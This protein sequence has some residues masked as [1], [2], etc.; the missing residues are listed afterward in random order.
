MRKA[1]ETQRRLGCQS[2]EQL[3]LNLDC[4]DEIV[5]ILQALKHVFRQTI[6]RDR[7]CQLVAGDVNQATRND[8]GREGFDYW[9]ILVMAIVRLGCNLDYDKLQD[10][11]ENHRALRCLLTVGDWDES[12]S[13]ASRRI[14][15]TLAML[16]PATITSINQLIVEHAQDV[17]GDARRSIR[18][19]SFVVETNIHHPTE[20]SLIFDGAKKIIPLCVRLAKLTGAS[21]W[22]QAKHLRKVIKQQAREIARISASKSPRVTATLPAAYEKLLSRMV[23][24][25]QRA[26]TLKTQ[27][28][29]HSSSLAVIGL[30]AHCL[31]YT[32]PSP[33]DATLSRMPSSA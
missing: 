27:A 24:L 7:L 12:T 16:K 15:D 33:R 18:A 29:E 3:R 6:L 11:C 13:F 31:L 19:D 5:P 20:S 22:R 14:R 9:Q 26:E 23:D 21:G 2:I 30:I 1:Y 32:S 10:L 28:Q 8:T 4:R 17:H 25:L